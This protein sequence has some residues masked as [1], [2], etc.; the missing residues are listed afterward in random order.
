MGPQL[1][2]GSNGAKT[3]VEP[4]ELMLSRGP[5]ISLSSIMYNVLPAA[6]MQETKARSV[7]N[8]TVRGKSRTDKPEPEASNILVMRE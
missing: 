2:I 7:A 1:N 8:R 6:E 5:A 4:V 3:G